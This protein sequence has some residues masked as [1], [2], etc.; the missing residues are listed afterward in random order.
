MSQHIN[1]QQH[2]LEKCKKY[3]E[4]CTKKEVK[5]PSITGSLIQVPP[6]SDTS[7]RLEK[8]VKQSEPGIP[9][10]L[11]QQQLNVATM[12][13]Q[14]QL[15]L[16]NKCAMAVYTQGLPF[17][18]WE[19]PVMRDFLTALQPAYRTPS[20]YQLSGPLLDNNFETMK[21]NID[22]IIE[23]SPRVDLIID[24]SNTISNNRVINVSVHTAS[25]V[26]FH[27]TSELPAD[28][29]DS[30]WLVDFIETGVVPKLRL[31][32]KSIN[33]LASDTCATMRSLWAKLKHKP[34][35][36]HTIFIP[37]DSHGIQLLIK[38]VLNSKTLDPWLS[39]T[40]K[41]AQKIVAF[42]SNAKKQLAFLRQHQKQ[43]YGHYK[44]FVIAGETRWGTQ[45]NMLSSVMRSKDA[46]RDFADDHRAG[47]TP[48]IKDTLQSS[49]FWSQLDDLIRLLKP[50]HEFQVESEG[51]S[52]HMGLVYAR[53][54]RIVAHFSK[55]RDVDFRTQLLTITQK[56][57]DKQITN[58]HILAFLLNPHYLKL[59][60]MTAQLQDQA[61][62]ALRENVADKD[63]QQ[64]QADFLNFRAQR[65]HF[66]AS[67]TAWRGFKDSTPPLLFWQLSFVN[68]KLLSE[69][70][71]RLFE[72]PSNSVPSERAFSAMNLTAT[73][74]RNR[75]SVA[76]LNKLCYIYMNSR[77]LA[78]PHKGLIHLSDNDLLAMENL[79]FGFEVVDL[80]AE[81]DLTIGLEDDTSWNNWR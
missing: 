23:K 46:L 63:Y 39:N 38:D 6:A 75:L 4:Y 19:P 71:M 80:G 66:A 43:H 13:I 40:F 30:N 51:S 58:L 5:Q 69:L 79:M 76:K 21:S 45:Y 67:S 22:D 73:K 27:E 14:Q 49:N 36:N 37:C 68:A 34:E 18:T 17:T 54:L 41:T 33:S 1:H 25:G 60:E 48:N 52:S 26:F 3:L 32:D 50:V 74:K 56:R 64:V 15:E 29:I 77:A 42:F 9:K 16:D 7:N 47:C 61:L 31:G 70:A 10:P 2:H 65:G 11:I 35:Y 44:S 78:H 53:W 59:Y 20:P 55:Q 81:K 24:E 62:A 28:D 12:T 57:L 8:A 72:T